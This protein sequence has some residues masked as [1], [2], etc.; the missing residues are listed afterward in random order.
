MGFVDGTNMCPPQFSSSGSPNSAL[1]GASSTPQAEADEYKIWKMHDKAL[2]Q[3]LTATL[4]SFA[5][6]CAIGST[7]S[8]DLWVRLQEQFSTISRTSIFQMKVDLQNIKKGSNSVSMYL[9]R[10]KAA[11]D[12]LAA[13]TVVFAD[14]D[15]V[16]LA[17]NGLPAEYNTFKCV[18]RGSENVIS[19][20]EFHSQ[21][22]AYEATVENNF[23]MPFMSAMVA[24]NNGHGSQSYSFG[25]PSPNGVQ[26]NIQTVNNRGNSGFN[27]HSGQSSFF[28]GGRSKFKGKGKFNNNQGQR[29]Y[30]SKPVVHDFAPG[31]LGTPSSFNSGT[32]SS[33]VICQICSKQGHSAATCNFRNAEPIE[34][35]QICDRKNHTAR[36]CFF[37]NQSPNQVPH[38]AAMNTTYSH[39]MSSNYMMPSTMSTSAPLSTPTQYSPESWLTDSGATNHMTADM[40]NLSLASPYPNTE[41]VQTIN[42]EGYA[43]YYKRYFC[44]HLETKKCYISRHV[45]FNELEFPFPLL[46][47]YPKAQILTPAPLLDN[48]LLPT[49]NLQNVL[50]SPVSN[51]RVQT[52]ST[53]RDTPSTRSQ[54]PQ[55]HA[56][57]SPTHS[58]SPHM[59]TKSCHR[60]IESPDVLQTSGSYD[61]DTLT[62]PQSIIAAPSPSSSTPVALEFCHETF[63][64]VLEIPLMNLHPMQ[65]QSKSGIVKH[66]ALYASI[67][68]SEGVDLTTTEPATYKSALK[69]PVWN[70]AMNE[71]ITALHSQRTWSLV[72][73]PHNKNLVGCKWVFKI[74]RNSDGTIARYKARL[75]AKGFNQEHGLDYGE[76]FSPV[77]KP[78]TVSSGSSLVILLLYVDDI[79][80]T[81]NAT[82]MIT[83][84]SKKQQTVSRSS[85]EA[86]YRALS[87]TAAELD[88]LQQLFQRAKHIKV[89]VHFVR[90]RV[91]SKK[92]VFSLYLL[93]SSLPTF[94][95]KD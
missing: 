31:I 66:K 76:T 6:S 78:T 70:E 95:P 55:I 15:I 88:W 49:P 65:T 74:K 46:H 51:S 77:V 37:R 91:A 23:S 53:P 17:L 28:N 7:S 25:N 59:H 42:G 64:V 2:M 58:Q 8:R 72:N 47:V 60:S 20:K 24:K 56:Q 75:V 81:G 62:T 19:L 3:L 80:I 94:L 57:P 4:S 40:R 18:I 30:N 85:T 12:F 93:P 45:L 10:I 73:L 43:P 90:E 83:Q 14:E 71:E 21:L 29:Y 39:S 36:T 82:E 35:C 41:M 89:D 26:N 34:P 61:T 48:A 52:L 50:V 63:Q 11:Q 44:Y 68:D 79:I 86:E 84:A 27:G 13:A 67:C 54:S 33:N 69:E 5:I 92:L 87:S 16:I 22:L 38:M 1:T 32:S 9:Q